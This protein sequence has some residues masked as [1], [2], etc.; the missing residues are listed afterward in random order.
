MAIK[1]SS[2]TD[3]AARMKQKVELTQRRIIARVAGVTFE[4][5]QDLLKKVTD[6]TPIKLER[7][8][9]NE[10][11]FNAIKVLA[12]IDGEWAHVGFLPKTMSKN[13]AKSLDDGLKLEAGVHKV[14]GG[15]K[16][17][18]S[19]EL[20]NYGLDIFVEGQMK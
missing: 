8:R 2:L 7:D 16:M 6:K 9:R 19:D 12:E 13:V 1:K 17:N 20:L 3:Y 18:D 5:R 4:E 15:F 14:K 10:Y 11:D